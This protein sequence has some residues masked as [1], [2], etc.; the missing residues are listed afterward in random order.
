MKLGSL[1]DRSFVKVIKN[2]M[3]RKPFQGRDNKEA[4]KVRDGRDVG[5][6]DRENRGGFQAWEGCG[7][8][9]FKGEGRGHR[10]YQSY[11]DQR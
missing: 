5:G 7:Q 4:E 6:I 9:D 10:E 2:P 11:G 3:E 8:H 1:D